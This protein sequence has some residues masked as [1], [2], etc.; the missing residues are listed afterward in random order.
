[1]NATEEEI[2]LSP[3]SLSEYATIRR[4]RGQIIVEGSAQTLWRPY[5]NRT[6]ARF[7]DLSTQAV[8]PGEV[9]RALKAHRAWLATYNRD[10]DAAHPAN[11]WLY[12]CQDHSYCAD[13]LGQNAKRNIR[14][15]LR[16]LRIGVPEPSAL[17]EQGFAAFQ[18]TR[19]RFGLDDGTPAYFQARIGEFL[20]NPAHHTVAA[21]REDRL[22]AFL[23][24]RFVD[25]WGEIEGL[26]T[27]DEGKEYRASNG[28]IHHTLET[29]LARRRITCVSYG[30]SSLQEGESV[31]SLHQF[32]LNVGFEALPVHRAFVM[33]PWL[34]PAVNP[35][36]LKIVQ[37][38][39]RKNPS[40]K[41]LRAAEGLLSTLLPHSQ[42]RIFEEGA[43]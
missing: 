17:M 13:A 27:T 24:L 15:A 18:E 4:Q 34:R 28:V 40:N 12:L 9:T 21:W 36:T 32:K 2:S 30:L 19:E 23:T 29:L 38:A 8:A 20:Q 25:D 39:A 11:A 41:M 5:G 37:I 31:E 35:L 22:M 16:D 26:F 33:R 3:V 7:P 1:M 10:P 6:I 14:R 42:T 43:K